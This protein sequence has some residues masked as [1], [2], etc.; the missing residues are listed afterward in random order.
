MKIAVFGGTFD[1]V[2]T[3]HTGPGRFLLDTGRAEKILYLPAW[4]PPHKGGDRPVTAYAHRRA[5]LALALDPDMEISDLEK[6]RPGK[7]YTI[8]TLK[9]LTERYPADSFSWVVGAD[10]LRNLHSWCRAEELVRTYSFLVLPRPGE[11][12]PDREEL[13]RHWPE[14]LVGRLLSFV[15]TGAPLF[16]G[17]STEIRRAVSRGEAET[18]KRLL[19]PAVLDYIREHEL[20]RKEQI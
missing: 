13:R 16:P 19:N 5:M 6:E 17:S 8:D 2:H 1:P 4:C 18:V 3:G 20:Y 9:I 10:S 15:V 11:S 12:M 14:D 7:S